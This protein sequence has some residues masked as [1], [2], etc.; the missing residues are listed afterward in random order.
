[1]AK[2][3]IGMTIYTRYTDT[4]KKVGRWLEGW[5]VTGGEHEVALEISA[6]IAWDVA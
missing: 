2:D 5:G 6:W 4:S 3:A 1:L